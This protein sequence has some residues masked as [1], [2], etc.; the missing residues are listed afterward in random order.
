MIL[1]SAKHELAWLNAFSRNKVHRN[2][3]SGPVIIFLVRSGATRFAVS[4]S[5]FL[6]IARN[7][8]II[9]VL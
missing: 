5:I 7:I 8:T 2:P 4:V 1:I 3:F 6:D 9:L